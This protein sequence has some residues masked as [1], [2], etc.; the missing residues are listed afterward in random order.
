MN[1]DSKML[2]QAYLT[3]SGDDV[4][5]RWRDTD[6]RWY[7]TNVTSCMNNY[8]T[9]YN[10]YK[11]YTTVLGIS[12]VAHKCVIV[13]IGYSRRNKQDTKLNRPRTIAVK[14]GFSSSHKC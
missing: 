8:T 2:K 13:H 4:V 12:I 1:N 9:C 11:Q 7:S 6:V 10:N 3:H 14:D 5:A